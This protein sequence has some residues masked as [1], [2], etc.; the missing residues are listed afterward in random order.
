M[1]VQTSTSAASAVCML[2]NN[3][4]VLS[5]NSSFISNLRCT[6]S[7]ENS[8]RINGLQF[9]LRFMSHKT[10]NLLI[11]KQPGL[12]CSNGC[13][14]PYNLVPYAGLPKSVNICCRVS[15]TVK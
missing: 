4:L 1:I 15:L 3:M 9:F 13:L 2:Y 14:L 10:T 7:S 11:V 5:N 6:A 12:P 8:M